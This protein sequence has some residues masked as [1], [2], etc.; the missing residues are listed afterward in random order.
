MQRPSTRRKF[1]ATLG[2][3]GTVSLAG[4]SSILGGGG[5]SPN[6]PTATTEGKG[7]SKKQSTTDGKKNTTTSDNGGGG[8]GSAP[9][10][11]V[12]NFENDITS[13]WAI[14]Y[15]KYKVTKQDAFQGSQSLVL[16]PKKS[17]KQPVAKISKTFYP[18]A[19]DLS[20]HDL[21]LAA[22][23]NKPK[24][25]QVDAE[26]IAASESD[27]LTATR[28]IPRE[29]NDWVRFD[30]GYTSKTGKPAMDSVAQLNLQI[31]PSNGKKFQVLIDDLRKIP[32]PKKG[33]VIFQFD[34]G[35]VS[36]YKKA[37]PILKKKGW[38]GGVGVIP[39]AV[40]SKNR[41]SNQMM[42][43]MGKANWDMMGHAG[44]LL[45]QL[46]ES[47]QRRTLQ[48]VQQ[49]L[50][51]KGFNKGSRHFVV[52]YSRVNNTTLKLIDEIYET[53]FLFGAAPNNAQHPSNPNFI[54]RVQGPSA[55]G[56]RRVLDVAEKTNQLVVIAYHALGKNYENG[57]PMKTFKEIVN[58]VEK[59]DMD[60]ITPS[61]LI[62]G[63]SW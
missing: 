37:F 14:N 20:N 39:D 15:G 7:G 51:V 35:H 2:A 44:E 13:R 28:H 53:G 22:K 24:S 8:G 42:R 3:A 9:G 55:R 6:D 46:S 4:C 48:Q 57:T 12:D 25:V 62:D 21:S 33:K 11:S 19:L 60:V 59:K 5:S 23:V 41:L 58:H 1:I 56:T 45:P 52:P 40:N 47:K 29:L 17:A 61:Q 38:P 27:M 36:T 16:E 26:I 54:S 49:A 31:K 32:K 18:K 50:K 10:K 30:L 63:K 34:D 43:E